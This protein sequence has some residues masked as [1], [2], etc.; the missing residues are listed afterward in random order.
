MALNIALGFLIVSTALLFRP[1]PAG[2]RG[3]I[4]ASTIGAS[5]FRRLILPVIVLPIVVGWMAL[6]GE[7]R[8]YY[9]SE[10]ESLL[11]TVVLI[12]FLVTVTWQNTRSLIRIEDE[13]HRLRRSAEAA[14]ERFQTA[15]SLSEVDVLELDLVNNRVWTNESH[16]RIFGLTGLA[17]AWT[18]DH[19]VEKIHPED[20]KRVTKELGAA[21]EQEK[22]YHLE[23]RIV[24]A[25]GSVTGRS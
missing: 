3:R 1:P 13:L 15:T 18:L 20:R 25:D 14:E 8:G 5:F 4:D 9:D 2:I 7:Q 22:R 19:F 23:F 10:T 16:D 11:D 6:W 12:V 24:W 21:A 17:P